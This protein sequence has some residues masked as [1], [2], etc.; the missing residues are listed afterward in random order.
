MGTGVDRHSKG[1]LG[2][3]DVPD[4]FSDDSRSVHKKFGDTSKELVNVFF[5]RVF[6]P[7][8]SLALRETSGS[9]TKVS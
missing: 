6:L 2:T 3:E 7:W 8:P 4:E 9:R 5:E 1:P